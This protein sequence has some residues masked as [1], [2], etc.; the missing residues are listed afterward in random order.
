[1]R[2]HLYQHPLKPGDKIEILGKE[3]ASVERS[4]AELGLVIVYEDSDLLVVEKPVGLLTMGP[5]GKKKRHFI[6]CSMN[7]SVPK[8]KTEVDAFILCIAWIGRVGAHR[9]REKRRHKTRASGP[10]DTRDQE[11]LRDHGRHAG[12]TIGDDRKLSQG[13]YFQTGL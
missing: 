3:R 12:G 13:R 6:L 9:F 5:S 7:T 10:L 11:I 8:R 2:D 1:M 4:K